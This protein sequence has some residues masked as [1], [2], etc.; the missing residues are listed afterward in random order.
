MSISISG[1]LLAYSNDWLL[2]YFALFCPHMHRQAPVP[3]WKK[4]RLARAMLVN[5]QEEIALNWM[6]KF[7]TSKEM[8]EEIDKAFNERPAVRSHGCWVRSEDS[9]LPDSE[10]PT[11]D[12]ESERPKT[13]SEHATVCDQASI[14]SF[15][16]G[17][18]ERAQ[19]VDLEDSLETESEVAF[20]W[21]EVGTCYTKVEK[22]WMLDLSRNTMT[23][24][25]RL[26]TLHRDLCDV[27]VKD[28]EIF[29]EACDFE[30]VTACV[31]KE[32]G[33]KWNQLLV[34][35]SFLPQ[36]LT[37]IS[38]VCGNKKAKIRD[39]RLWAQVQ[40]NLCVR[41]QGTFLRYPEP[42][43]EPGR[44]I[45]SDPGNC[46]AVHAGMAVARGLY[47]IQGPCSTLPI[48]AKCPACSSH[49]SFNVVARHQ[50]CPGDL[51]AEMARL[52]TLERELKIED[53]DLSGDEDLYG[54]ESCWSD[55]S[56]F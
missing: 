33:L 25:E 36:V 34:C 50:L 39:Q 26:S 54:S 1:F 16:L 53:E 42:T 46:R 3:D 6:C 43:Q 41:V 28:Q 2:A 18:S 8:R 45:S 35:A 22:L 4:R 19:A 29:V 23:V 12:S 30:S 9:G 24:R 27:Q 37:C 47:P 51:E 13:D 31:S 14:Q 15:A 11:T 5:E 32:G 55:S 10:R 52:D 7:L 38:E 40:G 21:P 49:S 20:E 56:S 17:D 44:V 48:L